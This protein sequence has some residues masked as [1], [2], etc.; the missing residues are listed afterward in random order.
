MQWWRMKCALEPRPETNS[1]DFANWILHKYHQMCE[2]REK[3]DYFEQ[4][5]RGPRVQYDKT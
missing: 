2:E 5:V 1:C 4:E 3:V